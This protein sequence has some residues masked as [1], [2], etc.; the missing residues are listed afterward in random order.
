MQDSNK[1]IKK[2]IIS[3]LEFFLILL[4]LFM[5]GSALVKRQAQKSDQESNLKRNATEVMLQK[6]SENA[7][8]L[9]VLGDSEAYTSISPM[10]I[11]ENTGIPTFVAAQ[12]GQTMTEMY[13]M[14]QTAMQKQKPKMLLIETHSLLHSSGSVYA[15]QNILMDHWTGMLPIFQYHDLWKSLVK[16]TPASAS[17]EWK[18]F[19]MRSGVKACTELRYYMMPDQKVQMIP[20]DNQVILGEIVQTAKAKGCTVI[21]YSAPS[22]KNYNFAIH[23]GIAEVAKELGVTYIDLNLAVADMNI[24]W[25][26]DTLDAGDHLNVAGAEKATEYMLKQIHTETLPSHK[27]DPRYES[28]NT[29]KHRYEEALDSS[30]AQI[31]RKAAKKQT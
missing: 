8:D 5:A 22:P 15:M 2:T 26:T 29:L 3:S 7:I 25:N 12:P 11:W 16:S 18:G 24:D 6:E 23:N 10:Q 14:F 13:H 28:W 30:M 20:V 4:L 1:N 27:E 9:L 31:E 21:L 19:K 17:T